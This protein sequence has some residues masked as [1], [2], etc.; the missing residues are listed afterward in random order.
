MA[1]LLSCFLSHKNS[2]SPS[3]PEFSWQIVLP[4]LLSVFFIALLVGH[5]KT[6]N[7]PKGNSINPK[8]EEKLDKLNFIQVDKP[9]RSD[10]KPAR[11]QPGGSELLTKG[12]VAAATAAL[13]LL[14]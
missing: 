14:L 3:V 6:A 9:G 11:R 8:L 7:Q 4:L 12:V 2:P 10:S 5:R 13:P 1:F